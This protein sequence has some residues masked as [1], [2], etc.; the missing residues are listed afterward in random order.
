MSSMK[1]F[2]NYDITHLNTFGINAIVETYVVIEQKSDIAEAISLYST[3]QHILWW[4]SNVILPPIVQWVLWHICISWI[5]FLEETW[6]YRVT[7]WA[8]ENWHDFVTH[9]INN[10]RRWI[11]N[12]I[13]IPWYCG[14]APVQNIGAYGVELQDVFVSCSVYNTLTQQFETLQ[15]N[16][17]NFGYRDSIFK[18]MPGKYIISDITVQL[19]SKPRPILTYKPVVAYLQEHFAWDQDQQ[20]IAKSIENIRWSKLPKPEVLWNCW[21]FF[22]NPIVS[23]LTWE[24]L[25]MTF[26]W[27]PLFETEWW[28][29]LSAAWLIDQAGLKWYSNTKVGTY[30]KQPLV[31]VNLHQ[32]TKLDVLDCVHTIIEKVFEKFWVTLEKEVNIW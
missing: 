4:W 27:I 21:S 5:T 19:S 28:Y 3:P 8:G 12:L 26:P 14:S 25:Q 9:T 32:A 23:Q 13:A 15:K 31:L 29:K 1:T 6:G 20:Y 16:E 11:E 10:W 30:D 17:C 22:K 24:T 18:R 7:V 2:F